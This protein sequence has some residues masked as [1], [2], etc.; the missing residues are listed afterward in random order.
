MKPSFL[1]INL[2][3][4]FLGVQQRIQDEGYDCYAW[5]SKDSIKGK[6]CAGKGLVTIVPDH[7][8]VIKDFSDKKNELVIMVDDNAHGNEMDHLRSVGYHVIGSSEFSDTAEHERELGNALAKL[9]GLNLPPTFEFK[10]FAS[11]LKFLDTQLP[12]QRFVFKA[13]GV[14]LAGSSKTY[15]S[16]NLEDAKWFVAWVEKD[17]DVHAYTVDS[18]ILQ[19]VIEG[20]EVDFACWFDGENFAPAIGITFEQK[21]VKGLGAAQGCMGQ[22]FFYIDANSTPA[23]AYFDRLA[24]ILRRNKTGPNEWAINTIVA[25]EDEFPYFLEFTP[26]FGWDSTFGELALLEDAGKS[27][28]EFFIRIAFSKKFPKDY[29]PLNK[30]SAAV[31]LF[32]ESGGT[33]GDEVNGKPMFIAPYLLP[34]FWWY[35]VRIRDGDRLE[36]TDNPFGVATSVANTPETAALEVYGL[37]DVHSYDFTVPDLW[38][39]DTIG[40]EVTNSLKSLMRFGIIPEDI[41]LL[42]R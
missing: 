34:N 15:V 28:A 17:Q 6:G 11:G 14:D 23:K 39:S 18:F 35:S 27:I 9:L 40:E 13:N 21:K 7:Y 31:R 36:I 42:T 5:Y 4:D 41:D 10:D 26:R 16:K 1:F 29:F 2:S 33:K 20:V 3:G 25:Y 22:I 32:S 12:E 30:Y 8:D 37:I 19:E 38:Y 24:P